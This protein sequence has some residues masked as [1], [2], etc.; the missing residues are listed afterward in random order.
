MGI[1]IKQ[2][3]VPDH[4]KEEWT[5]IMQ[6]AKKKYVIPKAGLGTI[7]F[8]AVD[9]ALDE[10]K[11]LHVRMVVQNPNPKNIRIKNLPVAI[12]DA[13]GSTII[14]GVFQDLRV[15]LKTARVFEMVFPHQKLRKKDPDLSKWKLKIAASA[16]SSVN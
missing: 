16:Q 13:T 9:M 14:K 5:V 10:K 7:Q 11:N 4:F 2:N 15:K 3:P 6:N 8:T 12:E 1:R